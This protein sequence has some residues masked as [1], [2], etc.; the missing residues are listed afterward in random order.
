[1]KAVE[2]ELRANA[3]NEDDFPIRRPVKVSLHPDQATMDKYVALFIQQR[4]EVFAKLR[5]LISEEKE[6]RDVM[7]E[8]FSFLERSG[9][10]KTYSQFDVFGELVNRA[11]QD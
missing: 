1:M 3:M 10:D 4:P 8:F 5:Q 11:R 9:F 7:T 2:G 6:L